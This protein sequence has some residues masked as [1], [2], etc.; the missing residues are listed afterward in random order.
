M[1]TEQ[2]AQAEEPEPAPEEPAPAPEPEPEP[3]PA[4]E[5]AGLPVIWHRDCLRH[6]PDGEVWLGVW[7]KGTEV[8]ERVTVVLSAVQ[9]AGASVLEAKPH[10]IAALVA[11][12]DADLIAHLTT[13][14]QRWEN[15]G[16]PADHGRT[17]VVP[18]VFPTAGL[19]AGLPL[20]PV[21]AVHGQD[22]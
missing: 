21:T 13:I 6:E 12:H 20:R 11:V 19:L 9:A 2:P 8:P 15:G 7:E 14:W 17:R 18:Y 10:G 22:R 4:G 3:E 1:T 16:Y 5:L